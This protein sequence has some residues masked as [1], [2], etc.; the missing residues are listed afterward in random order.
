MTA[1]TQ[2]NKILMCVRYNPGLTSAE[3]GA[4]TGIG[5]HNAARRL[6]E[7]RKDG[8]VWNGN[9]RICSINRA[10]AITWFLAHSPPVKVERKP[11]QQRLF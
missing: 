3:V 11:G 9:Q 2:R 10:R 4:K 7:L 1:Q 6:P 5:R 8:L